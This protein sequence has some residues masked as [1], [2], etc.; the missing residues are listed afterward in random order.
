MFCLH[1]FQN[2]GWWPSPFYFLSSI[3]F[4]PVSQFLSSINYVRKTRIAKQL[5]RYSI[6]KREEQ[7]P[8]VLMQVDLHNMYIKTQQQR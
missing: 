2:G 1:S 5:C 6:L 3:V 7:H 4:S 8:K